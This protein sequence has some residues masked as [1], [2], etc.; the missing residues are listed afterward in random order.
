MLLDG[1]GS[2]HGCLAR[3]ST[4]EST[5]AASTI[6]RHSDKITAHSAR[7]T[8]TDFQR[9]PETASSE[10]GKLRLLPS[11]SVVGSK[12]SLQLRPHTASVL[13]DSR[14]RH[15]QRGEDR[16]TNKSMTE[17]QDGCISIN[18]EH[19]DRRRSRRDVLIRAHG[20]G[21][22]MGSFPDQAYEATAMGRRLPQRRDLVEGEVS[23]FLCYR[24][25][26]HKD[27]VILW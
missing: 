7:N 15:R 18:G 9:R 25:N 19:D 13:G 16:H 8:A 12:C 23:D 6:G 22:A 4:P 3:P 1:T 21:H 17:A 27:R 26:V 11:S 14:P 10:H 5:A 24:A 20:L 2:E